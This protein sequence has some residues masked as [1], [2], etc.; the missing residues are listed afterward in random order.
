MVVRCNRSQ[1][2]G[3]RREKDDFVRL[4]VRWEDVM[5]LGGSRRNLTKRIFG[6][7]YAGDMHLVSPNLTHH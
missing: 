4:C 5:L 7:V 2:T 3:Y 1:S 6:I